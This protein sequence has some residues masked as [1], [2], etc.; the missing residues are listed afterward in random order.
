MTSILLDTVQPCNTNEP[1]LMVVHGPTWAVPYPWDDE[2]R[3]LLDTL[4]RE[5]WRERRTGSLLHVMPEMLAG[6]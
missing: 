2:A 1:D 5:K 3:D 6:D 4:R